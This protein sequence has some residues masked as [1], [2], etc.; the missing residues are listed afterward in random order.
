M[1]TFVN[2]TAARD[3]TNTARRLIWEQA[4]EYVSG[5]IDRAIKHGRFLAKI[6]QPEAGP[7]AGIYF[8]PR[9]MAD[10]LV[11]LGYSV[12]TTDSNT[13]LMVSWREPKT[14]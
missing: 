4:K 13:V 7:H 6:E 10:E 1:K 3:A 5:E 11:R 9:S 2:A 8:D 14:P 12:T